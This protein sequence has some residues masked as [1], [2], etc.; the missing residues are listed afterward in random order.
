MH[1]IYRPAKYFELFENYKLHLVEGVK[2]HSLQSFPSGHTATAFSIFLT[3]ALITKNHVLKL[4]CFVI[5]VL[6]AY[7][8][9]YLSQ[10]FFVDIAAGTV[11]GVV[12]IVLAFYY[13]ERIDK[14]WLDR[15]LLKRS[16]P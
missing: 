8:R 9:V 7:S 13:F 11:I 4:F 2:I 5:A 12:F 1:N 16:T 14:K 15:S 10:H 6:V 3:L